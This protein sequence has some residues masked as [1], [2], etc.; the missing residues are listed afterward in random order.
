MIVEKSEIEIKGQNRTVRKTIK[1]AFSKGLR[2]LSDMHRESLPLY[3]S[4]VAQMK[5]QFQYKKHLK[6]HLEEAHVL[7]HIDCRHKLLL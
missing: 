5:N 4:H 2:Q 7:I 6:Q 3:T 1:K